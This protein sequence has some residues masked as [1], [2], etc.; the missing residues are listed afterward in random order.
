MTLDSP[1]AFV[2]N[3]RIP[4]AG[5]P[6]TGANFT[7]NVHVNP[8]IRVAPQVFVCVNGPVMDRFEIFS[9]PL[10]MFL[11]VAVSGVTV[12]VPLFC[13]PKFRLCGDRLGTGICTPLP[14]KLTEKDG[15]PGASV[16][17]VR[18]PVRC[19]PAVGANSTTNPQVLPPVSCAGG[20][21]QL[22]V[23]TKSPVSA[24]L[25]RC[26]PEFAPA[27]AKLNKVMSD[28]SKIVVLPTTVSPKVP[29]PLTALF[30]TPRE[31]CGPPLSAP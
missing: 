5:P 2:V 18:V 23:C 14:T 24:M 22:L 10:P 11:S 30:G 31:S 9:V 12:V 1:D 13:S 28:C 15:V 17:I 29:T 27:L 25:V 20:I 8:G 19:P 16:M 26:A 7:L 3:E 21:G 6:E 4:P